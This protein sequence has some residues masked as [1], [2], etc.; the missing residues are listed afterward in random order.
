MKNILLLITVILFSTLAYA[1]AP[2]KMSYQSVIRN[3]NGA[4]VSNSPVA[5]KISVLQN[6]VGG[7]AVYVETHAPTTNANGLAT[8]EIG[9]GSIVSGTFSDINWA[10]G[11][12]FLK[13]ETDPT[14]GSTFTITGTS[15]L[16]S[17]PYA[18]YGAETQW[19]NVEGSNTKVGDS[20]YDMGGVGNTSSGNYALANNAGSY[21]TANG[22]FALYSNTGGFYNTAFGNGSLRNNTTG[23]ANTAYGNGA[24]F[25]NTTGYS[26][27]AIGAGSLYSNT[28]RSN[29]V[30]VGDSALFNNGIGV[31][32][33]WDAKN[34]IAI[35][36]KALYSNTRGSG[37]T[38]V[39][40]SS[41]FS[42]TTGYNNSAY[43]IGALSN[44]TTGIH[45]T[46]L[47]FYAL[48]ENTTA[49]GNTA[50]EISGNNG[51]S[52]GIS[53]PTISWYSFMR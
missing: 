8:I 20:D 5:I 14:G 16:L 4:L 45:N 29:L 41:L 3:A 48:T 53:A 44:N 19:V 1:Q 40:V 24:L 33:S 49:E 52:S 10:D 2:E 21:N 25:F 22:L 27:V 11:P 36:S 31:I 42:N 15:Q 39:G 51:K 17:V 46:A 28:S 7:P 38:A 30:A 34:N 12:Y 47:G 32:Y 6:T 23:S 50:A 13:T 43:G 9:G 26:N 18:L 35:G 37:N